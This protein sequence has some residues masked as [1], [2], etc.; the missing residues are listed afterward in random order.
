MLK[1]QAHHADIQHILHNSSLKKILDIVLYEEKPKTEQ[2]IAVA[3]HRCV[4]V[5]GLNVRGVKTIS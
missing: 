1:T 2:N 3:S 5:A 4:T